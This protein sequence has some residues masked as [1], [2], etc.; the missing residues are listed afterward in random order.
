MT[1]IHNLFLLRG[2]MRVVLGSAESP[3][4]D[5]GEQVQFEL[6]RPA[7]EA[8]VSWR[9]RLGDLLPEKPQ[10]IDLGEIVR[11]ERAAWFESCRG[12]VQVILERNTDPDAAPFG[13]DGWEAAFSAPVLVRPSKI[14]EDQWVAM[15]ADLEAVAVDLASDLIGKAAAGRSRAVAARTPLDEVVA[16][17]RLI[18]RFHR[19]MVRIAEQPHS[20]LRP[21][22]ESVT[23]PIRRLDGATIKKL[24]VRGLDP[25]RSSTS[26]STRQVGHRVRPSLNVPEHRQ[27]L[28]TLRA[29]VRSLSEGE[30]RA[31]AEIRE[32]EAD[33]LWRG[34]SDDTPGTSLYER[35]DRPRIQKLRAIQKES[36]TLRQQAQGLASIPILAGLS[37]QRELHLSLVSRHLA[38]YRLAWRAM[39]VWNAAGRAQVDTGKQLRRKD[40][41]RMYEQWVFLQLASGLRALGFR[42]EMEEDVFRRIRQR[43]FLMDLPRG[44]R[45]SFLRADGVRL[46]L[47]FEPWIRPRDIAERMGDMFFH[48]RGREAAWSPDVLMIFQVAPG[49]PLRAV[50]LDAKYVKRLHDTHWSGVRKYFQIR[51]LADGG[52]P[53]DQV[54]LSA[55]GVT[56]IRL[57]DDSISW[58]AEGPDLPLGAGTIQGEVGLAPAPGLKPG[59]AAPLVT[60]FLSAAADL[61]ASAHHGSLRHPQH[62]RGGVSG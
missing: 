12:Q 33:R 6:L 50:V 3:A 28:G 55:P 5:E 40:T 4:L 54:W 41:A 10:G 53:V 46:D 38:P 27:M 39:C 56:G 14:T 30:N 11:W 26:A 60:D 9:I 57:E 58:T 43:R 48:G 7:N 17:R 18:S 36:A 19:A 62:R 1:V 16:A 45:L 34:R 25:R 23:T 37:P 51:R 42:L 61:G 59:A 13:S 24:L 31:A 21:S 44:A 49:T 22:P 35:L 20:V 29:V 32:L 47:H 15:R 2:S 52:Q 8:P